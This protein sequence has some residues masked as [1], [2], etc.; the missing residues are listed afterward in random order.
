MNYRIIF[1]PTGGTAK[2]AGILSEA[3][4][5]NSETIDLMSGKCDYGHYSIGED[6]VCVIAM[7]VF[8]GRVPAVAVE[9]MKSLTVSG[10]R[11]VVVAVYGNRAIDDALAEMLDEAKAC[12]F[13]VIAAVKA[14]AEHSIMRRYGASRPDADDEKDLLAFAR[15]IREKINGGDTSEPAVPGNRPYKTPAAM[16]MHPKRNKNCNRCGLCEKQ[17]PVGAIDLSR[18]NAVDNGL[19]IT[20]MHCVSICPH[21]AVGLN[22]LMVNAAAF[23]MRKAFVERKENKL[24]LC[25]NL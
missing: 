3:L 25:P 18:K 5:K 8:S 24:Y 23:A 6:D 17:C 2:V 13:R 14:V 9:R 19:C 11:A 1:S 21:N 15:A 12:G 16:P 10:A 4:S 22:S 7:P 20:C